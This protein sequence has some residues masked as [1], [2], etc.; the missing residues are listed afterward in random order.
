MLAGLKI[1]LREHEQVIQ[2]SWSPLTKAK[3][4][5]RDIGAVAYAECSAK[6]QQG[7]KETFDRSDHG[8]PSIPEIAQRGIGTRHAG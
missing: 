5:Q 6:T 3:G 2:G 1:D 8:Q 7:L 4:W